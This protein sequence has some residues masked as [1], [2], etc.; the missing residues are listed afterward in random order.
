MDWCAKKTL[1]FY[2]R[3]HQF[4]NLNLLFLTQKRHT[5]GWGQI[6]N[7]IHIVMLFFESLVRFGLTMKKVFLLTLGIFNY[8]FGQV[9]YQTEI[10]T[11][12]TANCTGCHGNSGGLSLTSY[13]SVMAGGNSG[14]VIEPGNHGGSLLWQEVNLSLIHI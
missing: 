9:D 7:P 10:Q 1:K 13:G 14:A 6:I 4:K 12:F 3:A 5:R 2:Q 11:I 8:S